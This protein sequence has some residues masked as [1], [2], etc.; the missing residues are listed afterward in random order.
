MERNIRGAVRFIGVPDASEQVFRQARVIPSNWQPEWKV[1]SL[2][3]E[4]SVSSNTLLSIGITAKD[5]RVAFVVT[6]QSPSSSLIQRFSDE[7]VC[8]WLLFVS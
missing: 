2:D 5:Q 1:W 7:K 8:C 4:T 3:I 6:E